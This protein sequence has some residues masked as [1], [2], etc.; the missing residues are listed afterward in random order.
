MEA[1]KK[2]PKVHKYESEGWRFSLTTGMTSIMMFRPSGNRTIQWLADEFAKLLLLF[3]C[4][5]SVAADE[6][7][8]VYTPE[9]G[10]TAVLKKFSGARGFSINIR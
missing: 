4:S 8:F 3:S 1:A 10:S 5:Q 9:A 2:K 7:R 6:M